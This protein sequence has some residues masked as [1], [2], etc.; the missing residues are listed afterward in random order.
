MAFNHN[1]NSILVNGEIISGSTS[2]KDYEVQMQR[3]LK[4]IEDSRTGAV[5]LRFIAET[6]KHLLIVP[7]Q[8]EKGGVCNANA[9]PVAG[10]NFV[11]QA[12]SYFVFGDAAKA[13]AKGKPVQY[14]KKSGKPGGEK[15]SGQGVNS[16]IR[17]TPSS[18]DATGVCSPGKPGATAVG[19]LFHE[20]VHSYRH[21]SGKRWVLPSTGANVSYDNL[22]EFMAIVISNVFASDP[23]TKVVTRTLRHH[24][25]GFV[26]LPQKQQTS[27][28]FVSIKE[29]QDSLNILRTQEPELWKALA[30]VKAP[31]NP[32]AV[33][34]KTS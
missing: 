9:S 12:L 23:T 2:A 7:F 24:H 4:I 17:F 27:A 28:G 32:F 29:N 33:H 6:G 3:L 30:A 19:V 1:N 18:W 5:L 10:S 20:M 13:S 16:T 21:M 11:T 22:E 26:P 14:D 31:F 15:G 8:A 34:G 25:H